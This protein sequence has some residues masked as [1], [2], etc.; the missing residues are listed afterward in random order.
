MSKINAS[1][2]PGREGET[3]CDVVEA[4]T[5]AVE[6]EVE[7]KIGYWRCAANVFFNRSGC[8]KKAKRSQPCI[9]TKNSDVEII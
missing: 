4:C 2:G 3:I 1:G 6:A 8:S 7:D 9:M 5:E